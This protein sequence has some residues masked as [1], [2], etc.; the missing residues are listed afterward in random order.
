MKLRNLNGLIRKVEGPVK[1]KLTTGDGVLLV[2]LVKAE[3]LGGLK[4]LYGDDTMVET[5]L[6]V[7]DGFLCHDGGAGFSTLPG[8][9]DRVAESQATQTEAAVSVIDLLGGEPA[10]APAASV[11]DLLA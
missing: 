1:I 6:T 7:V 2:G 9:L 8:N 5:T 4:S 11:I 3:L 10:P